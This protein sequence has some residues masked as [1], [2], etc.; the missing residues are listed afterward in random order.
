MKRKML[1]FVSGAVCLLLFCTFFQICYEWTLQGGILPHLD[2]VNMSYSIL[3]NL[4]PILVIT[5]SIVGVMHFSRRI[6]F[7]WLRLLADGF[8]ALL[9]TV[10]V[11]MA[12]AA[13]TG[14]EVNWGGTFFFTLLV[15]LTIELIAYFRQLQ[16]A[17]QTSLLQQQQIMQQRYEI[18]KSKINPHFL[19]NAFNQLYAMMVVDPTGSSQCVLWLSHYY[20]Y[21]MKV[22]DKEQVLLSEERTSIGDYINL[23]IQRHDG[24]LRFDVTG[25]P[26]AT[27]MVIPLTL[28]VLVE[29]VVKHNTITPSC[30]MTVTVRYQAEGFTFSNPIH[31][32]LSP[33]R[34]G[35]GLL[36]LQKEY[37]LHHRQMTISRTEQ[38]FTVYIPYLSL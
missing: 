8:V 27:A 22:T 12:F 5:L 6:P 18:F 33:G 15:Y 3:L 17:R 24:H 9:S 23:I 31:P 11:N 16:A 21:L 1:T 28:Q 13:L 30:P 38:Q 29:N 14:L 32:R 19:F 2:W 7:L 4:V 26:P 10:I 25:E 37:E 36:Y 34:S 35:F 20:R